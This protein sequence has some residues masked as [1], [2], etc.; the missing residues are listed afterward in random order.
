MMSH[1]NDSASMQR[2]ISNLTGTLK[3][4]SSCK[5]L[6]DNEVEDFV[7]EPGGHS[8]LLTYYTRK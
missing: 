4:R 7:D 6:L 8:G 3:P 5:F 1:A 2:T